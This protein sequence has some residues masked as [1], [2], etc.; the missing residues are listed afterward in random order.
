MQR[1]L[2]EKDVHAILWDFAVTTMIFWWILLYEFQ[3]CLFFRQVLIHLLPIVFK[4]ET[5]VT[6]HD[7]MNKC[8]NNLWRN[9]F[10]FFRTQMFA[11]S[12]ELLRISYLFWYTETYVIYKLISNII[13]HML[14]EIGYFGLSRFNKRRCIDDLC[15]NGIC[16]LPQKGILYGGC[17]FFTLYLRWL[18]QVIFIWT[19]FL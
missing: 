2:N 19:N 16:G 13:C 8:K 18:I 3:G 14:K 1:K 10:Q 17:N 12:C 9:D 15:Q 11:C 4:V 6:L 7:D 5:F